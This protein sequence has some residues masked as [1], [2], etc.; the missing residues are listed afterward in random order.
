MAVVPER[1]PNG[2]GFQRAWAA[3]G[4]SSRAM[5]LLRLPFSGGIQAIAAVAR[6]RV[7]RRWSWEREVF[8]MESRSHRVGRVAITP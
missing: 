2:G 5:R 8:F 1:L 7:K 6:A 4:W 3:S